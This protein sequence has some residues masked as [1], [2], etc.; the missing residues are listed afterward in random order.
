MN[1]TTRAVNRMA[2]DPSEYT[3]VFYQCAWRTYMAVL[4]VSMRSLPARLRSH[5]SA[6]SQCG[7]EVTACRSSWSWLREASTELRCYGV[8]HNLLEQPLLTLGSI[9]HDSGRYQSTSPNGRKI[10]AEGREGGET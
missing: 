5:F 2:C 3:C 9:R 1:A 7:W 8:K 10:E 4:N 6:I